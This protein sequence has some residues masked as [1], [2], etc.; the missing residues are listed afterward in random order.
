MSS[1]TINVPDLASYF[2]DNHSFSNLDTMA[3][4][5]WGALVLAW[6]AVA[7]VH[8]RQNR[9]FHDYVQQTNT[10]TPLS[11][12]LSKLAYNR[13]YEV[14]F[15]FF[16]LLAGMVFY[17]TRLAA[18]RQSFATNQAE[19]NDLHEKIVSRDADILAQKRAL[20]EART[21]AALPENLEQKLDDI[22][23]K[24]E[25]LFINYYYLKRCNAASLQDFHLMNS[26]LIY[27]LTESNAPAGLRKNILTAARGTH[28]EMYATASC[29]PEAIGP[30]KKQV[31]DY[32][33][34]TVN[35][36]PDR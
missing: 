23:K 17:D 8:Q 24:Y 10:R 19:I 32:I 35:T 16:I 22:K 29:A 30:I 33:N 5:R 1:I 14:L 11:D 31:Q 9:K 18:D 13:A 27:E 26:A 25:E 15:L 34:T 36:L 7:F 12:R 3:Y 6:L 20:D 4:V 2:A 21:L 28:D